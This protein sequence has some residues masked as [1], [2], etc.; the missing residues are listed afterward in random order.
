MSSSRASQCKPRLLMRQASRCS[1]DACKRRGNHASGTPSTRPSESPT[2]MLS[3][4]NRTLVG[5]TEEL[6]PLDFDVLTVCLDQLKKFS[7]GRPIETI[8]AGQPNPRTQPELG[9]Y[10]R[11][12]DVDIHWFPPLQLANVAYRR[13]ALP[14]RLVQCSGLLITP[15]RPCQSIDIHKLVEQDLLTHVDSRPGHRPKGRM[16]KARRLSR[17]VRRQGLGRPHF[18]ESAQPPGSVG[19]RKFRVLQCGRAGRG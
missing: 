12:V 8:V 19:C 3:S 18:V 13:H 2:H 11:P 17:G 7:Q 6:S 1:G 14:Q 9:F 4:S 15:V 5:L 16:P 10:T